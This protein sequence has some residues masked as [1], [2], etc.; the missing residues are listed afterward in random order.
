MPGERGSLRLV[1]QLLAVSQQ[2]RA[3]REV[4]GRSF[5]PIG[6]ELRAVHPGRGVVSVSGRLRNA[7]VNGAGEHSDRN[8]I[9][10]KNRIPGKNAVVTQS[11]RAAE[12]GPGQGHCFCSSLRTAFART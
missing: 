6:R 5:R 7:F 11:P 8:S 1:D 3:L 12:D 2:G 9:G 4:N 10:A